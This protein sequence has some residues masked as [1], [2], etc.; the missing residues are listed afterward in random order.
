MS[1]IKPLKKFPYKKYLDNCL[2]WGTSPN[3]KKTKK[4]KPYVHLV[5]CRYCKR[6]VP[7]TTIGARSELC[8]DCMYHFMRSAGT[9]FY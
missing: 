7:L 4:K 6:R 8:T 9:R 2:P 1:T 5:P 3:K